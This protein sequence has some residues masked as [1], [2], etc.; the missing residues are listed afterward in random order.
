MHTKRIPMQ[1]LQATRIIEWFLYMDS[2]RFKI[3]RE[4]DFRNGRLPAGS[5][6]AIINSCTFTHPYF[7]RAASLCNV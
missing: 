1:R 4:A 6:L 3:R 5:A 2:R 7:I